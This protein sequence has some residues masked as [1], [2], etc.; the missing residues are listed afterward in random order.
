M[1]AAN[2]YTVDSIVELDSAVVAANEK[3]QANK[4]DAKMRKKE[5][6][7]N[8]NVR[9]GHAEKEK[10]EKYKHRNTRSE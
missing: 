5:R 6:K 2:T 9:A 1:N 10:A 3:N 7:T 8:N 4:N